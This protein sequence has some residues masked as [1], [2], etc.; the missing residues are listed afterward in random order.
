M[1]VGVLVGVEVGALVGAEVGTLV[2]AKVGVLVGVE[3]GALVGVEVGVL[4]GVEGN[5]ISIVLNGTLARSPTVLTCNSEYIGILMVFWMCW[6]FKIS[7]VDLVILHV[8]V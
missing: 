7:G 4:V 1:E 6:F 8:Q 2:G 5:A 3:V